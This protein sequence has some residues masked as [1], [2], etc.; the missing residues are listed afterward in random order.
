M[1]ISVITVCLN[2]EKTIEQ[3]IQ[4]VTDQNDIDYEYIIIDGKSTD[5]TLEIIKIYKDKIS[6]IKSEPDNG[7]YDAMNKGITLATGDI[8]GIINSDD[9]Y[10]PNTFNKIRE[11]FKESGADVVYGKL[12]LISEN[13]QSKVLL[14]GTIDK[15]RYEMGIPH[16]TVFVRRSIYK[17]YGMFNLEYKIAADYDLMLR[18]Y[19]K[20]VKFYFCNDIVA[21]F[22]L[23]GIS[24]KQHELCTEE[25]LTIAS[26][27]LSSVPL[28]DRKYYKDIISHRR[29]VFCFENLLNNLSH[30]LETI[31]RIGM[32]VGS[33]DSIVIF[34]A[35]VWGTKIYNALVKGDMR[36]LFFIDNNE[37]KWNTSQMNIKI[38]APTVLKTYK[39]VLI[40][41]VKDFS[42]D[43]LSQVKKINS[44][45]TYCIS[46][47]EMVSESL[48]LDGLL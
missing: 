31:L 40:L 24:D 32:G 22:R 2:S 38:Y 26:T 10:E 37:E 33:D 36:P 41:A 15:I 19:V 6:I 21:N 43:I 48:L 28:I 3:T 17:K 23:G 45:S 18:L 9:W 12:N 44:I 7:I 42:K 5:S 8:I 35:G 34:G 4:S 1:K 14:P 39:G 16:P 47:E 46:W 29:K 30:R 27:Y 13:G 20:G 11:S 25:T